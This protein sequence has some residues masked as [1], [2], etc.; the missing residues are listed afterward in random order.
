MGSIIFDLF[1]ANA[2][3]Y[4]LICLGS[5]NQSFNTIQEAGLCFF[6]CIYFFTT[7]NYGMV[8]RTCTCSFSSLFTMC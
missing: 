6:W 5:T 2:R 4:D 8:G 3:L 1:V 7:R